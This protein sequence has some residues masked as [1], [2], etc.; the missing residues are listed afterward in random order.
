MGL[1][2]SLAQIPK[3]KLACRL[4]LEQIILAALLFIAANRQTQD[5]CL[6]S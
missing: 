5:Q 3:R 6:G 4:L 1:Y 2:K